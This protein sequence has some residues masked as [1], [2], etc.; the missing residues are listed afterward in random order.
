M[1]RTLISPASSKKV[2]N[3]SAKIRKLVH[4]LDP[5]PWD[6]EPNP[7]GGLVLWERSPTNKRKWIKVEKK[8]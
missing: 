8:S 4:A 2:R 3:T 7:E 6:G 5:K 1:T